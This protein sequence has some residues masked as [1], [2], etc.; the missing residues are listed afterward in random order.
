MEYSVFR[1]LIKEIKTAAGTSYKSG[2][3]EL[4]CFSFTTALI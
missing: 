4:A 2:S 1:L 3:L